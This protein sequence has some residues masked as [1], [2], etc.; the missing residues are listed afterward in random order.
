SRIARHIEGAL[1]KPRGWMDT[2]QWSATWSTEAAP[3]PRAAAHSDRPLAR[4]RQRPLRV[5]VSDDE[6]AEIERLANVAGMSVSAY[7]RTAGLN[8]PIRSTFDYDAVRE[9]AQVAGDLGRLGGLLKLW[10][11]EKKGLGQGV[12]P[13]DVERLL[14]DTRALQNDIRN[15][16]G[17]V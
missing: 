1:G 9:L 8:H 3:V 4:D 12:R 13:I 6:R 11:T 7:L 16:M 2:P 10:L 14:R 17:R 5:V 15:M